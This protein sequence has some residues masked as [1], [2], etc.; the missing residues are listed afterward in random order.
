MF[1]PA[2]SGLVD[3]E[4][5]DHTAFTGTIRRVSQHALMT[6]FL[7]Q[8]QLCVRCEDRRPR[9]L[10]DED[11]AGLSAGQLESLMNKLSR[12]EC[13]AFLQSQWEGWQDRL[14]WQTG[15]RQLRPCCSFRAASLAG[16][17]VWSSSCTATWRSASTAVWRT[18]SSGVRGRQQARGS[19]L[20]HIGAAHFIEEA[21]EFDPELS[22]AA[23]FKRIGEFMCSLEQ[24][25]RK[26]VHTLRRLQELTLDSLGRDMMMD[27]RRS[28][29]RS[30]WLARAQHASEALRQALADM[31]R[32]Q[33]H[34][35]KDIARLRLNKRS[36]RQL[37]E[38]L[39]S[40]ELHH[41]VVDLSA[42]QSL[43]LTLTR[44]L[45]AT[46]HQQPEVNSS[47]TPEDPLFRAVAAS[48]LSDHKLS[49]VV[50]GEYAA[51]L[52]SRVFA[53][54][55]EEGNVVQ[56]A[57]KR[58]HLETSAQ[59]VEAIRSSK[60]YASAYLLQIVASLLPCPIVLWYCDWAEQQPRVDPRP[61]IL[62]PHD[63]SITAVAGR[64][65][66]V[67][68]LPI[69]VSTA[70]NAAAVAALAGPF[71][72]VPLFNLKRT[73]PAKRLQQSSTQDR[74]HEQ[75]HGQE[76]KQGDATPDAVNGCADSLH[77]KSKELE[78]PS[79]SAPRVKRRHSSV[80]PA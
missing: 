43:E 71:M 55:L 33:L 60:V 2:L 76:K 15:V 1:E 22:E 27:T 21:R 7:N 23:M 75:W 26:A 32:L 29:Q 62:M 78:L 72:L 52:K 6:P 16:T 70:V 73:R 53:C 48:F 13:E 37:S 74:A 38:Q 35:S 61:R 80:H 63:L 17:S 11:E 30:Q 9:K 18:S 49:D 25:G 57:M 45:R 19:S 47:S 39:E 5:R 68:C 14:R 34:S 36:A 12:T 67:A 20:Y 69:P 3:H 10:K 8:W 31:G 66:H 44:Q 59:L 65:V 24:W 58:F 41:S 4:L 77:G 28:Q 42:I 54:L 64:E 40:R 46:F 50:I 79:S 56:K 51:A